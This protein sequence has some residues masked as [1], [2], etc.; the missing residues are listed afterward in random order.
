[1]SLSINF[2][3]GSQELIT[4]GWSLPI[5]NKKS[6]K[7]GIRLFNGTYQLSFN[8]KLQIV[9]MTVEI[10]S[11]REGYVLTTTTTIFTLMLQN[12]LLVLVA[13][14]FRYQYMR[15]QKMSWSS[16]SNNLLLVG[17]HHITWFLGPI[18]IKYTKGWK[19]LY[20]RQTYKLIKTAIKT[21]R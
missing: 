6:T 15:C 20:M 5:H 12:G 18:K 4:Y 3:P 10:L 16:S 1:M 17:V 9:N 13:P 7:F 2:F 19:I 11:I 21:R 8:W 14:F